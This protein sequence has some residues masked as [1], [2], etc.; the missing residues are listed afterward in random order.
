MCCRLLE[1]N[2]R[3]D[4][5]VISIS[6]PLT[7]PTA[8]MALMVQRYVSASPDFAILSAFLSGLI[9]LLFGLLN[10][11]TFPGLFTHLLCIGQDQYLLQTAL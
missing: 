10:L 7:G 11:G 2:E 9:I 3:K 1:G 4:T 8:I 6:H 5:Q